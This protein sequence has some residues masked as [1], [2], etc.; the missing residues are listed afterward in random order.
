MR[1]R[2]ENIAAPADRQGFTGF[3]AALLGLVALLVTA[4]ENTTVVELRRPSGKPIRPDEE[5]TVAA[6][7]TLVQRGALAAAVNGATVD[8]PADAPVMRE[9]VE[10]WLRRRGHL[11]PT[12][13][14]AAARWEYADPNPAS[15]G[16]Q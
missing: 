1:K 5:L 13:F 9:L 7:D 3:R 11:A 15:C 10:D 4:C 16:T 2:P 12:E 6:L 8:V 14:L